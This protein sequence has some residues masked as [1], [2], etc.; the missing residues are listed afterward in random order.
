MPAEIIVTAD[1]AGYC[2]AIDRAITTLA[3]DG[4][5]TRAAAFSNY[6]S[7]DDNRDELTADIPL[8]LHFNISSGTPISPL[9]QIPTLTGSDG[10]FHE[11][12]KYLTRDFGREQTVRDAIQTFIDEDFDDYRRQDIR[13]ELE[14]QLERFESVFETR[15]G[16]GSVHH[17]LGRFPKVWQ[18]I[19]RIQSA[20]TPRMKQLE[21]G[22][23]ADVF[24]TFVQN[25]A[26]IQE[27]INRF[28]SMIVDAVRTGLETDV[29]IEI[30]CHPSADTDRLDA[31]TVY[32][33][34]RVIE[35]QVLQSTAISRLFDQGERVDDKW[36]F[37]HVPT[38]NDA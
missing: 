22:I 37:E 8:G 19:E 3:R 13:T 28:R 32:T 14:R 17:N 6:V 18:A 5:V 34:G 4:P 11:P 12:R 35:Y 2:D 9:S 20:P 27:S 33:G 25:S 36:R 23:I 26:S 7:T 24:S 30:V 31:F 16:F 10:R 38:L 29:P 15:P 21:D 1:D